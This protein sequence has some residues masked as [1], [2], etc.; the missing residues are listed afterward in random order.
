[1]GNPLCSQ[2]ILRHLGFLLVGSVLWVTN[3]VSDQFCENKELPSYLRVDVF[4]GSDAL[5]R[6][7]PQQ[8]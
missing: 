5:S 1:M 4:K 3:F 2:G 7:H 6:S 8:I